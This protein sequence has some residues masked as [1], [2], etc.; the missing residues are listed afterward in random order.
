MISSASWQGRMNEIELAGQVVLER[1]ESANIQPVGMFSVSWNTIL[2]GYL[3]KTLFF[4]KSMAN[5]TNPLT[6]CNTL[7]VSAQPDVSVGA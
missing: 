4:E 1:V 6:K 3:R 7:W 2:Q 5:Y